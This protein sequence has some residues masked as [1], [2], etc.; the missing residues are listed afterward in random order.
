MQQRV[1]Q[2]AGTNPMNILVLIS[3]EKVSSNAT[4]SEA[5]SGYNIF[6]SSL[7]DSVTSI[8]RSK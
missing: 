5:V 8:I 6:F 2:P 4:K 7:N 3:Y 1:K